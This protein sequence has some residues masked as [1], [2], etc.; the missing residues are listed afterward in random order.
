MTV[1]SPPPPSSGAVYQFILNILTGNK[2]KFCCQNIN[3]TLNTSYRLAMLNI[4][5]ATEYKNVNSA[6]LDQPKHLCRQIIVCNLCHS[7]YFQ[8]FCHGSELFTI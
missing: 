7:I 2:I 3:M 8:N 1:Y 5:V 4:L 6:G